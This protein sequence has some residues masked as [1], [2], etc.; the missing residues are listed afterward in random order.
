RDRNLLEMCFRIFHGPDLASASTL[1]SLNAYGST[2]LAGNCA[3]QVIPLRHRSQTDRSEMVRQVQD[4]NP[5]V[6]ERDCLLA[7]PFT[8]RYDYVTFVYRHDAVSEEAMSARKPKSPM[9][10]K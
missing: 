8:L 10:F 2:L 3:Q 1:A 9:N 6:N 4:E 5:T 7:K